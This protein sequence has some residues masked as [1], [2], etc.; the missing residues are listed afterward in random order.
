MNLEPELAS[1]K[2]LALILS[3]PEKTIRRWIYRR[4]IPYRK[5]GSLVRFNLAEVREWYNRR[6]FPPMNPDMDVWQANK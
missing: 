3:V 4:Q 6:N 2:Q 5:L 1:T